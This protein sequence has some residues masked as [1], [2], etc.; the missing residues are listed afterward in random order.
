MT[1]LDAQFV[2]DPCADRGNHFAAIG[3][4]G[5]IGIVVGH[6]HIIESLRIASP[7][8]DRPAS[9]LGRHIGIVYPVF[10]VAAFGNADQLPE[11]FND[12]F[13]GA[14]DAFPVRIVKLGREEMIVL[15]HPGRQVTARTGDDRV[16]MF[17]HDDLL[18]R[19]ILDCLLLPCNARH[20]NMPDKPDGYDF[21][22]V[23]GC[24][25]CAVWPSR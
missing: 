14:F 18:D 25:R 21:R 17:F 11:F 13:V 16:K 7:R 24:G 20:P 9:R 22:S 6:D 8:L 12:V 2:F 5:N 10:Y 4:L 23:V 1:I 15:H 19:F 3:R